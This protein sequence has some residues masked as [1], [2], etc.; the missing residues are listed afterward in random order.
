MFRS[1]RIPNELINQMIIRNL[2]EI[3]TT[4]V[5]ECKTQWED[6][7]NFPRTEKKSL[8][9]K[10]KHG[11]NIQNILKIWEDIICSITKKALGKPRKKICQRVNMA[12]NKYIE[13]LNIA[14]RTHL[15]NL[16]IRKTNT[17]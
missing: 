16:Q 1:K 9:L 3:A 10:M 13:E 11:I 6:R 8:H 15:S 7:K 5:A 4:M 14:K 17:K 12:L 2:Q